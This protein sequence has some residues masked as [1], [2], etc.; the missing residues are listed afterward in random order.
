MEELIAKTETSSEVPNALIILLIKGVVFSALGSVVFHQ[1]Y[2][3][4]LLD[5]LESIFDPYRPTPNFKAL[6]LKDD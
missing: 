3:Y 2:L 1:L 4:R 5:F 6:Q